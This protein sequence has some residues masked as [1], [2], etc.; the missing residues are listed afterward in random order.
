MYLYVCEYIDA[1][2]CV[3]VC[4]CMQ[5]MVGVGVVIAYIPMSRYLCTVICTYCNYMHILQ[6]CAHTATMCTYCNY[7]HILQLCAHLIWRGHIHMYLCRYVD[8]GVVIYICAYA[9]TYVLRRR[10]MHKYLSF[11]IP[12]HLSGWVCVCGCVFVWVCVCVHLSV[13]VYALERIG[14]HAMIF[15]CR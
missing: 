11:Y 15:V 1:R 14:I 4:V 13:C 10:D 6:L 2:M 3:H 5:V 12:M 9:P 7:V 8:V